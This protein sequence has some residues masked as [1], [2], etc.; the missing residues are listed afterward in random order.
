MHYSNLPNALTILRLVCIPIILLGLNFPGRWG[1]FLAA[2]FFTLASITDILD[3]FFAR[4]FEAVTVLGKFLDPLADKLLV[5]VTMI[6]LIPIDRVPVLIVIIIIAR[7]MAM[8][9][10]RGIAIS[11]G[12]V[13]QANVLGKYKTI[14]QSVALVAL[15]LHFSYLNI[16]F[17]VVG[18]VFIWLALVLTIWSGWVYFWQ[19]KQVFYNANR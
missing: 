11:E 14:F 5:S 19:F 15:C 13:I 17:H 12:I 2:L 3:G 9:G 4:K 6:M 1:S 16:N 18:M 10:L 7:E 8:T